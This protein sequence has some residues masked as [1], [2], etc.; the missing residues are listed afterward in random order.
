[1][2][3]E[4]LKYWLALKF[5]EGAGNI[6]C[7]RLLERFGSPRNIFQQS[8]RDLMQVEGISRKV[9][10]AVSSFRGWDQVEREIE[11]ARK[12]DAKIITADDPS[13][14]QLL[15]A[16]P[17]R[18]FL[19]YV[20][21]ELIPDQACLAVVGSRR[22]G[23]YGRYTTEKFCRDLAMSG[24]CV[25]SGM[26]RGIDS[27]AH[28]GALSARGRT[29]AVLGSGL[30]VVY[31]PE[32][33]KLFD[34]IAE[35]G[36]V[37]SEYPFA[38]PP[39]AANF[40]PRNRIISGM[41]L[42]V[43][44]MEASEKSGSLITAR[45]ALEQGREVFA[46]PGSID[47]PG[48]RGTHRLIK[49]GA[50]LVE[51]VNDIFEEIALRLN[52]HGPPVVS[53]AVQGKILPSP[54]DKPVSGRSPIDVSQESGERPLDPI[55]KKVLAALSAEPLQIDEIIGATGLSGNSALSCLLTLELKGRVV[56]LPGK[57]F[58]KTG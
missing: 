25:V 11:S 56:Q 19:L 28:R 30:D 26:A 22:A 9:A 1:M 3:V 35:T 49:E 34:Q 46:V 29:V 10:E 41:S 43:V 55:E 8:S 33:R 52:H 57:V 27:A 53:P 12:Y 42:G 18:P 15:K 20:K 4:C 13:Y 17:D 32:N 31:P 24:I 58:R 47:H 16:I 23:T 40:P 2:D 39:I 50:K 51:T 5:S 45:M 38:T 6:A 44:V 7:C 54:E 14:P 21:G 48:S 36:A 37:V